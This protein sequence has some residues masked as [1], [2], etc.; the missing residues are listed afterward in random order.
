MSIF[1]KLTQKKEII[2]L[3]N[4]STN[5]YEKVSSC[6]VPSTSVYYHYK[7][8]YLGMTRNELNITLETLNNSYNNYSTYLE[9]YVKI[10][11][12]ICK[13]LE[14][15]PKL[16]IKF[17][18]DIKNYQKNFVS[19]A[20]AVDS[21]IESILTI[22]NYKRV[23]DLVFMKMSLNSLQRDLF[24]TKQFEKNQNNYSE[25]SL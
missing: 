16:K 13:L 11:H 12:K 1:K 14:D 21:L 25:H 3:F 17:E 2:N 10:Y 18:K 4:T 8:V 20:N 22:P 23:P 6:L 9:T 24:F 19:L 7:F 15:E 5:I